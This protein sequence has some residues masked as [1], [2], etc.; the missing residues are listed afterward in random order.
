MLST[1]RRCYGWGVASALAGVLFS[2]GL[3]AQTTSNVGCI[4]ASSAS[5][6]AQASSSQAALQ[7]ILQQRRT[8]LL[9]EQT[10]RRH[11]ASQQAIQS[12]HQQHAADLATSNQ[13][14]QAWSA[15]RPKHVPHFITSVVVPDDLEK[16][17]GPGGI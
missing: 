9:Q 11:G 5:P 1:I 16:N 12:W 8:L 14:L 2:K 13:Q 4:Q 3:F 10:L 17:S 15:N 7:S 6:T